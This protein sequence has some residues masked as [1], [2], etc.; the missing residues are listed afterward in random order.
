MKG[1][2][3]FLALGALSLLAPRLAR[4]DSVPD[5]RERVSYR[6]S[7]ENLK[8]YPDYVVFYYKTYD[9]FRLASDK[10][11]EPGPD[12]R[13][14]RSHDKPT[15]YAVKRPSPSLLFRLRSDKPEVV[16]KALQEGVL[17]GLTFLPHIHVPARAGVWGVH[18]VLQIEK[19]DEAG[20]VVKPV[21]VI[22]TMRGDK[23]A[24][25]P[26]TPEGERPEYDGRVW[27]PLGKARPAASA[28]AAPS[29]SPS[30]APSAS[31]PPPAP[32]APASGCGGCAVTGEESAAGFVFLL[33]ALAAF[34]GRR[35]KSMTP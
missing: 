19:L 9:G 12:D 7:I 4:A 2:R 17:K 16:E 6:F 24:T 10:E 14:F 8:S 22:Y 18:D 23:L 15:L 35:R 25:W 30:A 3:G 26:F 5:N 28:S 31:A 32:P 34:R 20:F 11:K 29:V 33:G 27:P 1:R 13:G 21:K